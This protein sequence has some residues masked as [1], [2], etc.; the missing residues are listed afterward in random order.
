MS[1]LKNLMDLDRYPVDR[2]DSL[3][4]KTLIEACA[5]QLEQSGCCN[6]PGFIV[7]QALKR[8]V[9]EA[10]ELEPLAHHQ[11]GRRN[12]YFTRDDPDL[13]PDDPRRRFWQYRMH[14]V[15]GDVIPDSHAIR[16]LFAW[17]GLTDFFR[18]VLGFRHLYRMADPFQNLNVISLHEGHHQPWHYDQGE[19]AVTL[20]L[21]APTGGGHFEFVPRARSET[22]EN[23][24]R[25]AAI[26]DERDLFVQRPTREAG[27][28][29]IFRGMYALHRVT[30]VTG[31]TPRI[32]AVLSYDSI[33]DRYSTDAENAHIYGPRVAAIL[34]AR[35]AS[36]QSL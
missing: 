31:P 23:L 28:L 32:T 7:P 22:D 30:E 8:M 26:M 3:Q 29:T 33:P 9:D 2:P 18:R 1:D 19:F 16:V 35:R 15:A 25:V 5:E 17:D 36:E 27:T 4:G 10:V 6:L 34:S 20:L 12:A 11:D 14:Q 24:E 21:Q 13:P